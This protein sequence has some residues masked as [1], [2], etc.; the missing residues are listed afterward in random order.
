MEWWGEDGEEMRD[1]VKDSG[2]GG[3]VVTATRSPGAFVHFLSSKVRCVDCAELVE[4]AGVRHEYGSL[5]SK[6]GV[7]EDLTPVARPS[8]GRGVPEMSVF[9]ADQ[10]HMVYVLV[11]GAAVARRPCSNLGPGLRVGDILEKDIQ[12]DL[13][14]THLCQD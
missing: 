14:R 6:L 9:G 4:A 2:G 1:G 8:E 3:E 13:A 7:A 5:L 10:E 11:A 12:S